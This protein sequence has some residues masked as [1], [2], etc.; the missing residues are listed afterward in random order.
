VYTENDRVMTGADVIHDA[1]SGT[2]TVTAAANEDMRAHAF[3]TTVVI[4][5]ILTMRGRGPDGPFDRR[6]RFTDTWVH[7]GRSWQIV[8]AQDYLIPPITR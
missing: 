7:R 1:T 5:G 2:D 4:T 3:G 8:A 6:Y